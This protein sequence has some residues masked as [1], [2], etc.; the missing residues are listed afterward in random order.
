[1]EILPLTIQGLGLRCR[2]SRV[3]GLGYWILNCWSLNTKNTKP[4]FLIKSIQLPEQYA[5]MHPSAGY[6]RHRPRSFPRT[7]HPQ[8]RNPAETLLRTPPE[9]LPSY[10]IQNPYNPKP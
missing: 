9:P 6:I 10:L 8:T 4:G 7:Q 5:P 2:M 3:L 1:M